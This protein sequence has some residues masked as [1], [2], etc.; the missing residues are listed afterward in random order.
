MNISWQYLDKKNAS[1]DALKDYQSMKSIIAHTPSEIVNVEKWII[2]TG[3]PV[4]SDMPKGPHN[5]HAGEERI[6]KGIEKIDVINERYQQ[7]VEYMTW[8]M[9]AW[10]ALAI[11][12]Q[13]VLEQFYLIDDNKQIDSVNNICE[14]YH[15]ERTSAY[16][17]KDRALSR[18]TILLYGK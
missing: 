10:D 12:E 5:V 15:I 7:A 4:L 17:K 1:I 18:L 11:D 3:N 13:F 16:K 14:R 9:P 2:G 8:F 6:L